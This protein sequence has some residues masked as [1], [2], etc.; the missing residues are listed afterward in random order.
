MTGHLKQLGLILLPL[1]VLAGCSKD[2]ARGALP[3]AAQAAMATPSS[4]LSDLAGMAD[5]GCSLHVGRPWIE[6]ADAS[7]RYAVE[8]ET[9][10][11]VCDIAVVTL[12]VKSPTG[13]VL[14]NWSGQTRDVPG[15]REAADPKAMAAAL[16]EWLDQSRGGYR[17]TSSLPGWEETADQSDASPS[18]FH[19]AEKLDKAAWESLR[20][21][22][23]SVF[24]FTQGSESRKCFMLHGGEVEDLGLQQLAS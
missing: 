12:T 6:A 16:G 2:G 15:L 14:V 10:G 8:A 22:K 5:A 21:Q 23:L 1:A 7:H 9:E 19:P 18:P 11:A 24:C 17:D 4:P 13:A 3:G 20:M